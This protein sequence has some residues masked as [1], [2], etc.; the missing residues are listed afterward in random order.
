MV[1][2]IILLLVLTNSCYSIQE[3]VPY[4]PVREFPETLNLT[5]PLKLEQTLQWSGG[6]CFSLTCLSQITNI[7]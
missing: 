7:I 2:G 3:R 1:C 6:K 4:N 5:K